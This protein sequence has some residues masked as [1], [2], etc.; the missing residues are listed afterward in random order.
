MLF[1]SLIY[2]INKHFVRGKKNILKIPLWHAGHRGF[3]YKR[4]SIHVVYTRK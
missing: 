1:L 2:W 4:E 3:T